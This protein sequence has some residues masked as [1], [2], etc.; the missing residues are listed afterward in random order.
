MKKETG[1]YILISSQHPLTYR[2]Y[3]EDLHFEPISKED[4]ECFSRLIERFMKKG[5]VPIGGVAVRHVSS[6]YAY[7]LQAMIKKGAE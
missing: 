2:D 5:Y 4:S 6:S 1:D 7:F 3:F